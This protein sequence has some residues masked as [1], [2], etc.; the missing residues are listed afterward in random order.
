MSR[1]Q[2]RAWVMLAQVVCMSVII[3]R[4]VFDF[5]TT[6][7][8]SNA[9]WVMLPFSII[10]LVPHFIIREKQRAREIQKDERDI[11]IQRNATTVGFFSVFGLVCVFAIVA[12]QI[13]GEDGV[14]HIFWI[15]WG[16]ISL[17][18]FSIFIYA[19]AILVQY[20]RGE[21]NG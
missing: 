3:G 9:P 10:I 4:L 2:K 5:V 15:T 1:L 11:L 8:V 18:L 21:R 19:V 14:I 13:F 16:L 17:L 12:E 20:G 6:N 7:E